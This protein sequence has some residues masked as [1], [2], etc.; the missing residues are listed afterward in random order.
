MHANASMS[1]K[2]KI[3]LRLIRVLG[4][5]AFGLQ[6]QMFKVLYSQFLV[7]QGMTEAEA[8]VAA[9][10]LEL[11]YRITLL[12]IGVLLVG[13]GSLLR[14]AQTHPVATVFGATAMY[15]GIVLLMIQLLRNKQPINPADIGD[16]LRNL[17]KRKP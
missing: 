16:V 17:A 10:S 3:R 14:L 7:A 15:A 6:I 11:N 4:F 5:L 8:E 1:P 2:A 12:A 13:S 9:A